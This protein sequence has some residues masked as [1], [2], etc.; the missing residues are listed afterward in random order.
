MATKSQKSV[1]KE[2]VMQLRPHVAKAA[3]LSLITMLL[4]LVPVWYMRDV[5]GPVIDSGSLQTLGVVT[6]LLGFSFVISGLLSIVRS[7]VFGAASVR[8]ADQLSWYVFFASFRGKLKNEKGAS[9]ALTDLKL[10]RN[11]ITSPTMPALLEAPLGVLFLILVFLIH[12]VMGLISTVAAL[13]VFVVSWRSE[14]KLR[15][16]VKQGQGHY[17]AAIAVAAE[18]GRNAQAIEAM[19]MRRALQARWQSQQNEFLL[20]Q[21][22]ASEIQAFSSAISKSVMLGQGSLV[23]GVGVA[24]TISGV[25]TME[26]GVYLIVGKIL[27]TKA[28]APMIQLMSGW[29]AVVSA[30][31]AYERLNEYLDRVPPTDVGMPLPAPKGA[32][33][34]RG[35]NVVPPGAKW[36]TLRDVN[37]VAKPGSVTAIIGKSGSGKTSLLR[38]LLGIWTPSSGTVRLD[39]VEISSWPKQQ[40]GPSIGYLPQDVELFDG[41]IA[42]NIARFGAFDDSKLQQAVELAG[43]SGLIEEFD[44]GLMTRIGIGGVVLSGGQRQKI[45]LARALY[46]TPH[47]IILDEPNSS[48]DAQ[49]ELD[50]IKTISSLRHQGC[51]IILVTHRPSLLD[52]SDYLLV[53]ANG[54]QLASGPTRA[55]Q[56]KLLSMAEEGRKATQD[57][58]DNDRKA[59]KVSAVRL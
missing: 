16:L 57:D 13:F 49:G 41:T 18:S 4:S 38:T 48:L 47:L 51:L 11:F 12:P 45:G 34:A 15:P 10:I 22:N 1:V 14:V 32:L 29:K 55:V 39:G 43:I 20:K 25:L 21:A 42:E 40:L 46:G 8:L 28:I 7:R 26:Q 23:L 24:L 2:T 52:V 30:I 19:G 5:Y 36:P 54:R 37:L 56:A 3:Y 50:L 35:L 6:L 17:S 58:V 44:D 33:I 59:S 27:A 9:T 31:D 53:L